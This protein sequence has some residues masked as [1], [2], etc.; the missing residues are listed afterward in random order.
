[1]LLLWRDHDAI[2]MRPWRKHAMGVATTG[3]LPDTVRTRTHHRTGPVQ[4]GNA[5]PMTPATHRHGA[6]I[7]LRRAHVVPTSYP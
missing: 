5:P 6:A 3:K 7:R 2:M 1:M 4:P